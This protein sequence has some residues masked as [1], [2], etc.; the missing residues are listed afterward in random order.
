MTEVA[1][2]ML[3]G[4]HFTDIGEVEV[5]VFVRLLVLSGDGYDHGG[6]VFVKFLCCC[7]VGF[8]QVDVPLYE[9]S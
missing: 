2:V 1:S 6:D 8:R 5:A 7:C 4:G 3:P 9:C